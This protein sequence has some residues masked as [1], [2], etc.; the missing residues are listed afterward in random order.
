MG[1]TEGRRTHR[2]SDSP[3]RAAY[4]LVAFPDRPDEYPPSAGELLTLGKS[5]HRGYE[6]VRAVQQREVLTK[7][8]AAALAVVE[9][10]V[11]PTI[12]IVALPRSAPTAKISGTDCDFTW[13]MVRYTCLFNHTGDPVLSPRTGL[14]RLDM[15]PTCR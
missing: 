13:A 8:V 15:V 14:S 7:R 4:R 1:E 3:E 12:P 6:Y 10:L 11:A 2:N 9:F 5:H